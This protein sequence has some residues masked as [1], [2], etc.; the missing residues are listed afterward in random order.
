MINAAAKHNMRWHKAA[1]VLLSMLFGLMR[2]YAAG[3]DNNEVMVNNVWVD[4][5]LTQVF[6]D[7]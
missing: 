3:V 2:S 1:A 6:R 4:V 7:I 5:P